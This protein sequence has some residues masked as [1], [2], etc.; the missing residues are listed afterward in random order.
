MH[1]SITTSFSFLSVLISNLPCL[2]LTEEDRSGEDTGEE[3]AVEGEKGGEAAEEGRRGSGGGRGECPA[4]VGSPGERLPPPR[5]AGAG[6]DEREAAEED[7]LQE[8]QNG[9]CVSSH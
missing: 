4:G 9:Q 5:P 6:E 7:V 8:E 2:L 1:L 3:G